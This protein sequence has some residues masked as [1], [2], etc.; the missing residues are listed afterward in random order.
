MK[1]MLALCILWTVFGC[2]KEAI[3]ILPE[4]SINV[5]SITDSSAELEW[6]YAVGTT[7]FG[8]EILLNDKVLE[9]QHQKPYYQLSNLSANT[10]YSGKVILKDDRGNIAEES[11]SFQTLAPQSLAVFQLNIVKKTSHSI[12]LEWQNHNTDQNEVHYDVFI[13]EEKVAEGLK[14]STFVLQDLENYTNY[15]ISVKAIHSNGKERIAQIESRTLGTAPTAFKL[16]VT[17]DPNNKI[18]HL[19]DPYHL[20]IAWD[21]PV[22]PDGASFVYHIY[23][24]GELY[25]ENLA[26]HMTAHVFTDLE[27]NK[28]YHIRVEAKTAHQESTSASIKVQTFA[29][30]KI[31]DLE[32]SIT[33]ITPFSAQVEWLPIIGEGIETV[34]YSLYVNGQ[35]LYETDHKNTLLYA[36][37]PLQANTSYT[38]IVKAKTTMGFKNISLESRKTFKTYPYN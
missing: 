18:F 24:N 5:A 19:L 14:S 3:E 26:A 16:K 11:F 2:N 1:K 38:A 8:F 6:Q 29:Y 15:R 33:Q 36:L 13:G 23:V 28:E 21:R 25:Q 4:I 34:A 35:L 27:E 37:W 7:S 9:K 32:M 12:H 20:Y 30:P 31:P 17:A 10:N 22:V